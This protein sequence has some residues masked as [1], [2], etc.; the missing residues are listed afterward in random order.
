MEAQNTPGKLATTP[1]APAPKRTIKIGRPGYKVTKSRDVT[2]RQ[3]CLTFEIDY[4]DIE[5]GMQPRHRF[6]SS[7]EQKVE[8][9]DKN[10]QY[11]LFA[12]EPYETVA[13]KVRFVIVFLKIYFMNFSSNYCSFLILFYFIDSEYTC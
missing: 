8:Q 6:M 3:R 13:F 5:S 2:T 1:A 9:P 11:L 7:Y 10:F 12:C 4:P